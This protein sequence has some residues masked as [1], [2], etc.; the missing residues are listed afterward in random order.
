MHYPL[1]SSNKIFE[2]IIHNKEN[3]KL[4]QQLAHN[5]DDE[6]YSRTLL[7]NSERFFF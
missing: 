7:P 3:K 1:T 4:H 6:S 2:D 5:Y